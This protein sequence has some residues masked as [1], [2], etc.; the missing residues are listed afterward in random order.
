MDAVKRTVG[1]RVAEVVA[2]RT[3][4]DVLEL[5]PLYDSIDP[6]ALDTVCSGLESGSITFQYAGHDVTVHADRSIELST[7]TSPTP[8]PP[9][10]LTTD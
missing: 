4:R 6:D 9:E 8:Q 1:E 7:S 5:P 10:R 2:T 3:D